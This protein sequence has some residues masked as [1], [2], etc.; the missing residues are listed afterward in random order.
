[1]LQIG[2]AAAAKIKELERRRAG[3][4]L[5]MEETPLDSE[6]GASAI[7]TLCGGHIRMC[8]PDAHCAGTE[9]VPAEPEQSQV[10]Q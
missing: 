4:R 6:D 2:R 3:K 7:L 5:A 10:R 1:M 8:T 9:C